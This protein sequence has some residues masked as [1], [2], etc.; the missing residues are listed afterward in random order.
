MK[1]VTNQRI[2]DRL[3]VRLGLEDLPGQDYP[4]FVLPSSIMLTEAVEKLLFESRVIT[5]NT[6]SIT[7]GAGGFHV[8]LTVPVG[9][10]WRLHALDFFRAS[11]DNTVD[12]FRLTDTSRGASVALERFSAAANKSLLLGTPAP[13]DENDTLAVQAAGV[14]SSATVITM[15][16]LVEEEDAF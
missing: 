9:K 2:L 14:G 7:A 13:L 6:A 10:R 1:R 12:Q 5:G 3:R 4:F 16:A 15:R 11:G 8:G